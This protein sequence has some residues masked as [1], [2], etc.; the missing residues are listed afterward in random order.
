MPKMPN[1]LCKLGTLLVLEMYVFKSFYFYNLKFSN[2]KKLAPLVLILIRVLP[3]FEGSFGLLQLKYFPS[4][5][6]KA[7]KLNQEKKVE[8]IF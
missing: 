7:F 3:H 4:S 2:L 8:L 5:E 6:M 1:L